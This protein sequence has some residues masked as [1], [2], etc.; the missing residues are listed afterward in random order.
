[1]KRLY[2][3][4]IGLGMIVA[5]SFLSCQ[6]DKNFVKDLPCRNH[7]KGTIEMCWP[8]SNMWLI[9]SYSATNSPSPGPVRILAPQN[10]PPNFRT[11]MLTVEFD[12]DYLPDSVLYMC[13]CFPVPNTY[14]RKVHICNI[15]RDSMQVVV[16][17]PVIYLYPT[18]KTKVDV[19]LKY[20]GALTVTYPDYNE[21]KS[22]WTVE[23]KP[24]GTLQNLE[25]GQE[26]QYLF[27]EGKPAT[28]YDFDMKKGYCVE[29]KETKR[30]LQMMLPKLGLTPKEYNDM[31]V[32]W[33]PKMQ[34]NKYNIVHF[35]GSAYTNKAP[36]Q[37]TPEPDNMIR[38]FMAFQSSEQFV[39]MEEPVLPAYS[40]KGFTVVEWGGV[41]LPAKRNDRLIRINSL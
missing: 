17:K 39:E 31:I 35:A 16:L 24:D 22:G 10:L 34:D 23:A 26:Y 28:P 2:L 8:D 40:R 32:F 30:F 37:I 19:E 13:G 18:K 7:A 25:D 38:V 3:S 41:E 4:V 1:M 36:L 33:L 21:A 11:N 29:G 12:Y 20:D 6:K 14:A 5:L 15:Q 9:N 27:W